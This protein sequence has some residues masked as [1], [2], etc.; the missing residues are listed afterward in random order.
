MRNTNL[1]NHQLQTE[2]QDRI[3]S[4]CIFHGSESIGFILFCY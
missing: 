3:K 4:A 1:N 2:N